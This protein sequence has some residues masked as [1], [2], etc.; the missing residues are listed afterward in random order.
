MYF[1]DLIGSSF[2]ESTDGHAV[3][4]LGLAQHH[5][6]PH[7]F[8]H[9]GVLCSLAHQST[10]SAVYSMLGPGENAVMLEMKINFLAAAWEGTLTADSTVVKRGSQTAVVTTRIFDAERRDTC[11]ALATFLILEGALKPPPASAKGSGSPAR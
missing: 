11:T 6:G 2:E 1:D 3:V 7:G 8:V 10:G 5:H 9:G 4:R